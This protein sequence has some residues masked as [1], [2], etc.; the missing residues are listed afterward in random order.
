MSGLLSEIASLTSGL[1]ARLS[2]S[3]KSGELIK[4]AADLSD[5]FK[6]LNSIFTSKA[7]QATL[8]EMASNV[9][10][11]KFLSSTSNASREAL[12]IYSVEY[13]ANLENHKSLDTQLFFGSILK[14]IPIIMSDLNI[15]V[16]NFKAVFPL[17]SGIDSMKITNAYVLGYIALAQRLYDFMTDMIYLYDLSSDV[18]PSGFHLVN[19]KGYAPT[20]ASF[21]NYLLNRPSSENILV[22]VNNNRKNGTD[23]SILNGDT[24]ISDYASES[25]YTKGFLGVS[26]VGLTL[27][28]ITIIMDH[29]EVLQRGW[30]NDRKNRVEWM[31]SKVQ[32][33]ALKQMS[34]TDPK[35]LK[36]MESQIEFWSKEINE[37]N[38]LIS[39]YENG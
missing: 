16:H 18:R 19:L 2:G 12:K 23:V 39:K 24:N 34:S 14:A 17:F 11:Q 7:A 28:P 20:A 15:V 31:R 30:N 13:L 4:L 29:W 5:D 6:I 8:V 1:Q 36:A 27:N 3:F 21:V 22:T 26:K 35:E 32:L 37:T 9:K 10:N 33:L 38:L 25:D